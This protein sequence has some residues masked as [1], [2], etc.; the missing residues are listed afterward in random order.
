M[1]MMWRQRRTVLIYLIAEGE[2]REEEKE[3]SQMKPRKTRSMTV[4]IK[5]RKYKNLTLTFRIKN[6]IKK[7]TTSFTIWIT[8][9]KM[10]VK[11]SSGLQDVMFGRD[12]G[13]EIFD[14]MDSF[15]LESLL[16]SAELRI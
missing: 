11:E 5:L 13:S 6:V 8:K 15:K 10:N 7:M 1:K 9:G 2:K 14:S 4:K 3:S 12:V 16:F